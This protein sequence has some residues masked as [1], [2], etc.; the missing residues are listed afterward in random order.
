MIPAA[1]RS[2]LVRAP[3]WIG[4]AVMATPTL[5]ALRAGFPA[6]RISVLGRSAVADVLAGHPAVD[7]VV[8]DD[9]RGS[10]SGVLGRVRLAAE[11]RRRAF[12]TVLLLPNSF[13]SALAAAWA[14]V[15]TRVGYRTDGRGPLLSVALPAPR[16]PLPHMTSYYLGL[17]SAWG[18]DGDARAVSLAVT[19]N[20]RDNA[21]ERLAEWGAKS[22]DRIVAM[23]PGAAYGSAKRWP[24]ERFAAVANRLVRDGGFVIVLGSAAERAL[25]DTI[26]AGLDGR[27]VNAAGLTTIRDVMAILTWCRRLVTNDSGPMHLAAALGVPVTAIFG[28]TD[29]RATSPIGQRV[30][31]LQHA[32]DCAPCRYRDC[33]IDHRCMTA[34]SVDEVYAAIGRSA[35]GEIQI[36]FL[37]RDGTLNHD[38][39]YLADPER[40]ALLPGAAEA[41]AALNAAGVK[42][43]IVTNQSG[44]GRGL[45][46]PD[47]LDRIHARLRALLAERGA[48]VDGIYSCPHRPEEACACRKPESTLALRAARDLRVDATRSATIG[49][50]AVDIELGSRLGGLSILVQTGHGTRTESD[51]ADGPRP[52]YIARDLY[53]AVQWLG[54]SPSAR[55]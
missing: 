10:H 30:T 34:V 25:G 3:N 48:R 45:I 20:E 4:D 38:E 52:D 19:A 41:V 40:L 16:R 28:P 29:P 32:V 36:V 49:D 22:T 9:H 14:R 2:L 33:P 6:A 7:E 55:P 37:D 23:N 13:D 31:L 1:P 24:A 11:I 42:V 47:A 8:V 35:T 27:A 21:R 53:D 17:L 44:V 5:T 18:L 43:A 15:P 39:G 51:L 46:A 26:T 54:F 50:K 12:D